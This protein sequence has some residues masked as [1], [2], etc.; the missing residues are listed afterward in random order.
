MVSAI[1]FYVLLVMMIALI[2][3]LGFLLKFFGVRVS[4]IAANQLNHQ[5]K[6]EISN[7][8]K[9]K[10]ITASYEEGNPAYD[11]IFRKIG[12]TYILKP[13]SRQERN[14]AMESEPIPNFKEN[15][16]LLIESKMPLLIEYT[17]LK[18]NKV[19]FNSQTEPIMT[20]DNKYF[21]NS[22]LIKFFNDTYHTTVKDE[23]EKELFKL[24][25]KL[26]PFLVC[27]GFIGLILTCLIIFFMTLCMSK[28]ITRILSS[29]IVKPILDL[30]KKMKELA[31][32]NI[33]AA[34]SNE[35]VF[36]R[37]ITEVESL[38]GYTNIIMSKM[39]EY[40]S[41]LANQ[42]SEL[43]AQNV[44][45]QENSSDLENVNHKLDYKNS[46]LR[47]ILNNVE[48]GFLTFKAD[49]FIHGEYSLECEKLFGEFIANKQLSDLL[50]SD[51]LNAE[52]FMNELIRKIFD[53]DTLER[54]LYFPL[55]PEEITINNRT[56][57]L[58]YKIVK[59]EKN[60][61]I[62]MVIITDI[63][64]KRLLEKQMEEESKILKMVVKTIINGED[65]RELVKAYEEFT[66]QNFKNIKNEKHEEIYRQIHTFKGNF[67]QYEMVN[68]VNKLD[69]LE[70]K[71]YENKDNYSIG[72]I[73]NLLIYSWLKKDLDTI[74]L[75]TG[76]D[77]MQEG[78]FCYIKK[79][80]LLQIER[81]IQDTLSPNECRIILPLIKS[82]QYKSIKDLLRTYADYVVKLSERL[83]KNIAPVIITGDDV[84]IDTN[85]YQD[86]V[87]S[88]VHIFRNAV[89]HGIESEDERLE[90]GKEQIGTINCR[91]QDE[92]SNFK[93]LISDDGRG[94]N[95]KTLEE[96]TIKEGLY[97]EEE[98]SHFSS[99]EKLDFIY[100]Q[101][102]TTKEQPNYISGRGVGMSAV[103]AC[104][105]KHNGTI[106]VESKLNK[107]TVFTLILPKLEIED[108]IV[109]SAEDFMKGIMG[110]ARE[111]IF[112]QTGLNFEEKAI[113]VKN[114]I[115]LNSITALLS[116]KG[117]FNS[118]LMI[119]VNENMARKLVKGFMIETVQENDIIKYVEDVLGEISNTIIGGT[120]G[121]FQN[122]NN[123]FHIGIPAVL[124]N[125]GAYI[126]Y[127][128]SEILT[129]KLV[130]EEYEFSINMLLVEDDINLSDTEEES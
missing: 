91:V 50:Y 62:M 59:D 89:D 125:S 76:K 77:F 93:I 57:T 53:A 85:Y 65:F 115:S 129:C 74:E 60:E 116:L 86:V 28:F 114:I 113:E 64:E 58:D 15:M 13:N 1:N 80:K 61:D 90:K 82:L 36:K 12:I 32:G 42:N 103:K 27:A 71:L 126:K 9:D 24:E 111:I 87:K 35:I 121:K 112:S 78:E 94:I 118:I 101:G 25:V 34:M 33:E 96:K 41:A 52:N 26:N 6:Y 43:E 18:D 95:I 47:N 124:S 48:Q 8:V 73:D 16:P 38:A 92:G 99:F 66:S 17:V 29:V 63:T 55:L 67:S 51:N 56:I 37:P 106:E 79:D 69:E 88:L 75:Y 108:A 102:I 130:F 44:T 97:T 123:V 127:S 46:K 107:G 70:N 84:M 23:N 105:L 3:V 98:L 10:R 7:Y 110:T 128:Q 40:V 49:L 30:D 72:E 68:L 100:K 4:A 81:K 20:I 120:F 45:L 14:I 2:A 83:E 21:E 19:I 119:S 109:F 22:R 104:V 122:I 117:T 31:N 5:M 11:E 54:K 39:H